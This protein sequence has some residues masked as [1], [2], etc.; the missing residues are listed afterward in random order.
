MSS[1][2]A[3]LR[4]P[5]FAIRWTAAVVALFGLWLV[6][7][8]VQ[9]IEIQR[10]VSDKGIEAWL[11]EDHRVPV[12]SLQMAFRGGTSLDAAGKEGL[13]QMTAA[14]LDEGAGSL[15][16][17]EFQR[18][19]EEYSIRLGFNA[20]TDSFGGNLSTLSENRAVA[21]D[22]LRMSLTV[23]RFDQGPRD[24]IES[25][26]LASIQAAAENP[27]QIASETWYRAAY[28]DHPYGRPGRG[29]R[30]SIDRITKDD[31]EQYV[32]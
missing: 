4:M 1:Q 7:G 26:M 28:P 27:R 32:R 22:M 29:T 8:P 20:G 19:L 25:Q 2:C 11:V 31:L 13:S 14:L 12:I 16:S 10:V 6:A 15:D 24:R 17:Q 5:R 23:P 21:F 30:R 9:A 18:K 3:D